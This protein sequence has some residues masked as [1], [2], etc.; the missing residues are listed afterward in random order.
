MTYRPLL[1]APVL[2]LAAC[3]DP[4]GERIDDDL[5][6]VPNDLD[7][8][9]TDGEV[10]ALSRAIEPGDFADL[11]L[12]AR[13][14]GPQGTEV[15][16]S[17]SNEAG[18]LADIT[19]YVACPAGMEECDPS[20]APEGTVYTYVHIVYPGEDMDPRSGAGTGTDDV[21]VESAA[22]F[23]MTAPAYG[24]T[25]EAGYSSA[26][27]AAAAGTSV[28]VVVSCEMDGQIFWTVNAGDGG[29][30]WEDAEPITFYWR[31]TLPPAG[32]SPVYSIRANGVTATGEGPYPAENPA[33]TN[34]CTASSTDG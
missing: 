17:L 25:G 12:G 14:V 32:P 4:V 23:M 31:S 19:S 20:T 30:Q 18:I 15:K 24:F 9:T 29:D 13:I 22:G 33:A 8:A 1:I 34:A 26:E 28:N 6:A 10:E 3:G 11:E 2:L 27:V 5:D 7:V 21:D 16:T